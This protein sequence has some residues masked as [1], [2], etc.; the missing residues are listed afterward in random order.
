MASH[1]FLFSFSYN[2]YHTYI[3]IQANIILKSKEKKNNKKTADWIKFYI[4][5]I[6]IFPYYILNAL[7]Q[8]N[9]NFLIYL[10]QI[11]TNLQNIH[12]TTKKKKTVNNKWIFFWSKNEK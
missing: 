10:K 4:E 1:E 5:I 12:T 6:E 3:N 9:S 11:D 2:S 8:K 7:T